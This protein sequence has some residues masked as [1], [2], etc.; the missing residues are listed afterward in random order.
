MIK[1]GLIY[2][3]GADSFGLRAVVSIWSGLQNAQKNHV[4]SSSNTLTSTRRHLTWETNQSQLRVK[5]L[6]S[7]VVERNSDTTDC[8]R[9]RT[10]LINTVL[11]Y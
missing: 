2:L 10:Y 3:S 8:K 9:F 4:E 7:L 5:I 6:L 11:I 1:R